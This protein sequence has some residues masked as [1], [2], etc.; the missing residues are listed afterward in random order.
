ML[1]CIRAHS[2]THARTRTYTRTH[3][4]LSYENVTYMKC[5]TLNPA[6]TAA[7]Q[8]PRWLA[9]V[10]VCVNKFAMRLTGTNSN[11]VYF[12]HRT[13]SHYNSNFTQTWDGWKGGGQKINLIVVIALTKPIV[14]QINEYIVHLM[15]QA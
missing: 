13:K 10:F 6:Y 9:T 3:T 4:N 14:Q 15:I 2:L 5:L 11:I 12:Q 1:T 7:R 8:S